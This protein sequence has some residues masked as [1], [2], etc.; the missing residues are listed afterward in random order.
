MKKIHQVKEI[1]HEGNVNKVNELLEQ[2]CWILLKVFNSP[3]GIKFSLGR[4]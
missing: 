1:R 4:I 3:A 2:D